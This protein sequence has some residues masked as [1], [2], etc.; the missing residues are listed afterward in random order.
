M[1]G[2]CCSLLL[3]LCRVARQSAAQ[4][5]QSRPCRAVQVVGLKTLCAKARE[6]AEVAK[7]QRAEMQLACSDSLV[8]TPV[9]A[10]AAAHDLVLACSR[11]AWLAQAKQQLL[12]TL[13]GQ[14]DALQETHSRHVSKAEGLEVRACV[15]LGSQLT[16]W[17]SC[18]ARLVQLQDAAALLPKWVAIAPLG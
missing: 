14:L 5:K 3:K 13:R 12:V 6:Q 18:Q 9:P 16:S 8:C 17:S 7:Q 1:Q 15:L 2:A 11:A 10:L 4:C